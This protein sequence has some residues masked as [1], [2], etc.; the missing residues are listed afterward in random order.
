MAQRTWKLNID[1][2]R[3]EVLL[4]HGPIQDREVWL[5]GKLIQKGRVRLDFGS[6]HFFS[7]CD[8]PA[9]LGIVSTLWGYD[10][11]LRV[12]GKFVFSDKDKN[13]TVGKYV[14]KKVEERD[15]WI[16]LGREHNLSYSPSQNKPFVYQHRLIGY[17][18]DHVVI[19][20][21]GIKPLGEAS[22][23]GV[24]MIL[25]HAEID[26]EKS[27]TIINA[28]EVKKIAD[29]WPIRKDYLEMTPRFIALFVDV[30]AKRHDDELAIDFI[31]DFIAAVSR[32]LKPPLKE[33]CE[34][35]ECRAPLGQE[36]QLTLINGVPYLMCQDCIHSLDKIGEKAKEEYKK[37]PSNL[38]KGT[39]YGFAGM[40]LGALLWALIFIFL[41]MIGT[42][43][44]IFTFFFILKAMDYAQTKRSFLSLFLASIL[45]LAGSVLGTYIGA[46]GYLLKE[47]EIGIHLED[48]IGVAK[49]LI[50]EP[51]ILREAI[52]FS[53]IGIVP[54][55][56]ITWNA[57][58]DQLKSAFKPNV[59]VIPTFPVQA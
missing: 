30:D 56:F 39:I 31:F 36:L 44:A 8:H 24:L 14:R 15:K 50:E 33:K 40:V 55:L 49:F 21:P 18:N 45:A 38:L 17:A 59:E 35:M 4:K 7:I 1:G 43:F 28:Q 20:E 22:T 32:Y 16:A 6:D 19:I 54:Y 10:Y 37:V 29:D 42:A 51:E 53:L 13:Q 2:T 52:G 23:P 48:F 34:G 11:Y 9:E 57:N 25:R 47:K 41:D 3:H 5:D 58:R 12:D 46:I 26:L 27:Q